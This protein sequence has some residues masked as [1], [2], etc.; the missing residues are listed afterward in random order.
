MNVPFYHS[1]ESINR[2]K[3][4]VLCICCYYEKSLTRLI[5]N[6]IHLNVQ[7]I[8]S[9]GNSE[10][11]Q[12]SFSRNKVLS[13][14]GSQCKLYLIP[15]FLSFKRGSIT[16]S[17]CIYILIGLFIVFI[18]NEVLSE[19]IRIEQMFATIRKETITINGA[20]KWNEL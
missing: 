6:S 19:N 18:W 2:L 16:L 14:T 8:L 13:R 4:S 11:N 20:N 17:L 12:Y 5:A 1:K 3:K 15:F 7:C 10:R 9:G